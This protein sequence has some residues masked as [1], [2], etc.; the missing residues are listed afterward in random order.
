VIPES[1]PPVTTIALDGELIGDVYRSNV[2]VSLSA[3]DE[4][5]GVLYTKYKLDEGSYI[6]YTGSFIVSSEGTHMVSYYS[7]DKAGNIEEEKHASFTILF[8]LPLSITVEGGKGVT[9]TV[10]NDGS[11]PYTYIPYNI[12]IDGGLQLKPK[13]M[14]G[15]IILLSPNATAVKTLPVLGLGKITITVTV[16]TWQVT[17]TGFVF[18]FFV[19]GVK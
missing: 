9:V 17:K 14:S 7:V 12:S 1:I 10:T 13:V 15:D 2:T 6:T 5:S 4:G 8:A 19:L 11:T 16:D 3:T 18:L